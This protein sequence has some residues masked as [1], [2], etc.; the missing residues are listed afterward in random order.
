MTLKHLLL[1]AIAATLALCTA[2]RE[3][4]TNWQ[5]QRRQTGQTTDTTVRA[6]RQAP[7]IATGNEVPGIAGL[8]AYRPETAQP[9]MALAQTLLR[10]P[11][12]LSVAEREAIA[13]YVSKLNGC[14][15]CMKSHTAAACAAAA[16]QGYSPVPLDAPDRLL[17]TPRSKALLAIAAHVQQGGLYVSEADI[18]AARQAGITDQGIHD[19]VLVAAAF[20]MYN[21]Y[22]DGLGT[23]HQLP[24][25]AY[26]QMGA[27]LYEHGYG[28]K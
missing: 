12:T 20:C 5:P 7:F 2:C 13:G 26:R 24:D 18:A 25:T 28:G 15:Y 27:M 17:D 14:Q 19:A 22:V 8:L 16:P 4:P 21:R 11:S 23:A 9:L 1:T 10:G 6:P 3:A